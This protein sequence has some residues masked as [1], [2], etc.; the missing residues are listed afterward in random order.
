MKVLYKTEYCKRILYVL[1]IGD[2][3]TTVYLSS[4]LSGTGHGGTLL[5]FKNLCTHFTFNY[6]VGYI[7]KTMFYDGWK[8]HGKCLNEYPGLV[9]KLETIY[10][11]L[12][13]IGGLDVKSISPDINSDD[14]QGFVEMVQDKIESSHEGFEPFDFKNDEVK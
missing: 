8:H 9:D 1:Q 3:Y 13:E 12:L 5:P 10:N 7:N 11:W 2:K 6:P 14:W 4:G